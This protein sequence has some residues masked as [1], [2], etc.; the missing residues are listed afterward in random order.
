[1]TLEEKKYYCERCDEQ[2]NKLIECERCQQRVCEY[3]LVV[4]D[5]FNQIDF[6]CCNSCNNYLKNKQNDKRKNSI[7]N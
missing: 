1:M 3:C 4:Y 7:R 5:Q 2:S 6:N